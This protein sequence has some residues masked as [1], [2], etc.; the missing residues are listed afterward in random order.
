[1]AVSFQKKP[2]AGSKTLG[3]RLRAVREEA[4]ITLDRVARDT[5]IQQTY[6][7]AL[8][9]S[10]YGQLPSEVYARNFVKRYAVYLQLNPVSVLQLFDKERALL[11]RSGRPAARPLRSLPR[12][13]G[14][15]IAITPKLIRRLLIGLVFLACFTYLGLTVYKSM[16][17]PA[18]SVTEPTNNIITQERSVVVAGQVKSGAKVTING[19]VVVTSQDGQFR[20]VVNL[21]EGVNIIEIIATKNRGKPTTLYRQ[22]LVKNI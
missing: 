6:L 14:F 4:G 8:E 1:M 5:G 7:E 10:S 9:T 13:S 16:A 11:E 15:R 17:P 2:L 21:Q 3:E 22:V 12:L 20:E 18:L 19:Q